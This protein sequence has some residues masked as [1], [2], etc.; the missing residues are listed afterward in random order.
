MVL[1]NLKV[2]LYFTIKVKHSVLAERVEHVVEESYRVFYGAFSAAVK[3]QFEGNLSFLCVA[4]NF[5]NACHNLS[6]FRDR[7]YQIFGRNDRYI[8]YNSGNFNSVCRQN[9]D[10]SIS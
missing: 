1:V 4:F 10:S 9:V 7:I 6:S 8:I 3:I 2:A 5:C